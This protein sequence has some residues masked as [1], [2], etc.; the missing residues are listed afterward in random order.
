MTPKKMRKKVIMFNGRCMGKNVYLHEWFKMM[1]PTL[2]PGW[3][4]G[5]PLETGIAIFEF[6]GIQKPKKPKITFEGVEELT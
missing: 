1:I 6:K 2:K 5:V 4:M 3:T